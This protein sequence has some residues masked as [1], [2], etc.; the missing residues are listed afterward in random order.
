MIE[1]SKRETDRWLCS[2]GDG[3]CPYGEAIPIADIIISPNRPSLEEE[4]L[5]WLV[6]WMGTG[7]QV[8]PISLHRGTDDHKLFLDDGAH[9][10]AAAKRLGWTTIA[11]DIFNWAPQSRRMWEITEYL[12][13]TELTALER[14]EWIAEWISM[15]ET[16]TLEDAIRAMRANKRIGKKNGTRAAVK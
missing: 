14:A 4:K 3:R 12:N 13:W 1:S 8:T 15:M 11:A 5:E 7:R 9:R 10:I 6:E 16:V 2:V